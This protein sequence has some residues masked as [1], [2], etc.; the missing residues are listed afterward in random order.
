[1]GEKIGLSAEVPETLSGE[2][3]D[4]V[5]AELFPDYSRSKLAAW[6]KAGALTANGEQRRP[7]EQHEGCE[8]RHRI[9]RKAEELTRGS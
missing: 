5:A 7:H 1:M 3:L 9:A 4:Q 8:C 6:I 2:R